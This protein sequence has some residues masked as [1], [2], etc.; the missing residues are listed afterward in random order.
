MKATMSHLAVMRIWAISLLSE[1]PEE[2]SLFSLGP[3]LNAEYYYSYKSTDSGSQSSRS[4]RDFMD[5]GPSQEPFYEPVR[6]AEPAGPPILA[7]DCSACGIRLE[8]MR[9]VCLSCGEGEMW[10]EHASGRAQF[11][12]ERDFAEDE[13]SNGSDTV[14]NA[15]RPRSASL[16]TS[17]GSAHGDAEPETHS[18]ARRSGYELCASCIEVHGIA[19]AKAAAERYR[20]AMSST[21]GRARRRAGEMR[22]TFREK[23]WAAEG[24]VDV[25]ESLNAAK[26]TEQIIPRTRGVL[27]VFTRSN[28]EDSNVSQPS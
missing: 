20:S 23:S 11:S 22:H 1:M 10:S 28:G 27:S 26:L 18:R 12:G 2:V 9:Y 25:G 7:P 4:D 21:D 14:Y 8:Y 5:A 16:S 17:H 24:W 15:A 19:H 13:E 6:I 3:L